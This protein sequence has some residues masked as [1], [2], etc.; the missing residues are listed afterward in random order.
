[1]LRDFGRRQNK[2]NTTLSLYQGRLLFGFLRLAI[3]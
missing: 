2:Q 1:M 3:M